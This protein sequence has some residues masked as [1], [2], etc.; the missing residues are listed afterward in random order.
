MSQQAIVRSEA[1]GKLPWSRVVGYACGD[2]GCNVAFQMTGLFLLIY[3]TDVAGLSAADAA[4]IIGFVKLW[5]AFA[6]IFAGR[7]VD[8]TM[9]RWG[10]FRPF[11]L[12]FSFPLLATNLLAFY[13]PDFANYGAKLAWGYVTYALTGTLYSLVN[14]PFG[15]LAG[16]MTQEPAERSKLAGARMVGSGFTILVLAVL[17]APRL[18]SASDLQSTFLITAAVF[19]VVGMAFFMTLFF[20]AKEVVHRE[21]AQVTVKQTIQTVT[22]NGPLARL[23]LS[24]LFYLTAQNVIGAIVIYYARDYLAGPALLLTVVTIVTTGAVLYVGPFGPLVTKTLGKKRGFVIACGAAIVGG[25]IVL[26]AGRNIPV[27][28]LGLFV[29]GVG[30]ALLNT[31]TWALE[32]D[33]VEYGEWKTHIRTEGATYAAFSFTRKVGQA[34]GGAL[35]GAALGYFGYVSAAKGSK[36]PPQSEATLNGIHLTIS[37]LP[38]A[39]FLGA[40]LIMATYPLTEQ[41]HAEIMQEIRD[42]RIRAAAEEVGVAEGSAR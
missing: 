15:S 4:G 33:T 18:K 11:I 40:L 25:L 8:R 5:D 14:I 21:V 17:L 1:T 13:V 10:K 6:D 35:V 42:R 26:V 36:P 12:W 2:A 30:M 27:A 19:V 24:S 9:T 7:M 3:Y 41:R 29:T 22:K 34:I 16:A 28:L 20:T 38:S 32:A 37:L 39:I 23:C 31:M